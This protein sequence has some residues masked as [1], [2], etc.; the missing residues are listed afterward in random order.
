MASSKA[1]TRFLQKHEHFFKNHFYHTPFWQQKQALPAV[2][3]G[4]FRGVLTEAVA[5]CCW[6]MIV[7]LFGESAVLLLQGSNRHTSETSVGSARKPKPRNR[8]P[9]Q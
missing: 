4:G 8:L 2:C 1:F 5:F 3:F 9:A 6:W 7:I